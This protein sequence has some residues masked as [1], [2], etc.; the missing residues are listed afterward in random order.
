MVLNHDVSTANNDEVQSMTDITSK[1]ATSLS[2]TTLRNTNLPTVEMLWFS[3]AEVL[4][5]ELT[6]KA[7]EFQSD[8]AVHSPRLG[9]R[10]VVK[11][12]KTTS[13]VARK[14]IH[15]NDFYPYFSRQ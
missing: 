15:V 8:C 5:L 1:L 12:M 11:Q 3:V 4:R 6:E 13:L 10:A 2:L 9:L 14:H 7:R